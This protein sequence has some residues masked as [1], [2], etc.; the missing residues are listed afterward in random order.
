[1]VN[2]TVTAIASAWLIPR[3][4]LRGAAEAIVIAAVV[5][6]AGAAIILWNIDRRLAAVPSVLEPEPTSAAITI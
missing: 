6:L 2:C 5:Q 1:L 4:G 3:H